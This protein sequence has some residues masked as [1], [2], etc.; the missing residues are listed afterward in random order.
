MTPTLNLPEQDSSRP[1]TPGGSKDRKKSG[2]L[3]KKKKDQEEN[4]LPLAWIAGHPQRQAY[5]VTGL[6][7]GR[8]MPE[9]WDDNDGNCLVYLFPRNA[10][11]GPSF[12]IDSAVF[13]SSPVLSRLAFGDLYISL[14]IQNGGDRRQMP[15]DARTQGLSLHDPTT[16]PRSPRQRHAD[17]N[18]INSPTS[19]TS[20]SSRGRLSNISDPPAETHLYLPIKLQNPVHSPNPKDGAS[21]SSL[22]DLQTL[23]DIR[24]FFAFLCGQSL[25]ATPKKGNFFHIFMTVSGVLKTYEFSNLDGSTFGETA[26]G[27]FDTY[28]EELG[29]ADVRGSREKTIEGI[30]LGERMKS[31]LLYN[32]AFTHGAGKHEDLVN[33]KSPKFGLMSSITDNRLIRAAMDLD[34]R[35]A[36]AQLILHDFEFPGLFTG[37][38]ASKTSSE[39]KDGVRFESWK[40]AFLGFRKNYI[41]MLKHRFGDWP[42]KAKSKKND[43]E[44]SGLNRIVLRS[45]YKDMCSTY[46]ILVDRQS[47]TSRTVDGVNLAGEREESTIRAR[48]KKSESV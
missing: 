38:M 21:D 12:K 4:T 22:H 34:K 24:N 47:L 46:D 31:V 27:S 30:V 36:S 42:P 32:E 15:L 19:S 35:I 18:S 26:S 9:L 11:K 39:K 28:V 40:E 5:D 25:V 16:P 37:I 45:M 6:M 13:A 23:I 14:A 29:L 33:L 48:E 41:S 43:L 3:H 7:S 10:G 20:H 2:F 44:T 8:P 1:S 17:A